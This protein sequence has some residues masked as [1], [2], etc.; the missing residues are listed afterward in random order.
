MSISW[1]P[2]Q[3]LEIDLLSYRCAGTNKDGRTRCGM[4]VQKDSHQA[5][6]LL[7]RLSRKNIVAT[8]LDRDTSEMLNDIASLVLCDRWHRQKETSQVHSLTAEWLDLIDD[9]ITESRHE[10]EEITAPPRY[11]S[12]LPFG[13]SSISEVSQPSS[14]MG[15]S[16][17]LGPQ[18]PEQI[19]VPDGSSQTLAS[20]TAQH[21]PSSLFEIGF[22][23]MGL[24]AT[25][26]PY[27][28]RAIP[29]ARQENE[30]STV[31]NL[32][33]TPDTPS[34]IISTPSGDEPSDETPI[35]AVASSPS[36]TSSPTVTSPSIT[37]LPLTRRTSPPT[38]SPTTPLSS[39]STS[40]S[41][42]STLTPSSH[43]TPLSPPTSPTSSPTSPT[44]RV[45]KPLTTE[46]CYI[47]SE[48]FVPNTL[49]SDVEW[50]RCCGTN[51]HSECNETW[52]GHQDTREKSCGFCRGAWGGDER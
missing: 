1:D 22:Q 25:I 5:S 43:Q 17:T 42:S 28:L 12:Q 3:I 38:L 10:R 21:N 45:R 40:S 35:P 6:I 46:P 41:S 11:Q 13:H 44:P 36:T 51:V 50:C 32:E 29:H 14:V 27:L 31:E 39:S 24:L 18:Q 19:S 52:F 8:G 16:I 4:G 20:P 23:R 48:D 37:S 7:D 34:R 47:C 2:R 9:F 30:V 49:P 26:L 33:T 15:A